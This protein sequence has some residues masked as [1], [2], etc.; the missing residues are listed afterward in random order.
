MKKVILPQAKIAYKRHGRKGKPKLLMLHGLFT[1]SCY[2]EET[3]EFLKDEFDILTPD[4]PG[5]GYSDKL[6]TLPHNLENFADIVRQL[7]E[8]VDFK[9]FSL[10]GASLGAITSIVFSSKYPDFVDNVVLQAPPWKDECVNMKFTNKAFGFASNYKGLVK[11]AGKLKNGVRK[12]MFRSAIK[13]FNK[14]YLRIE[15]RN[16]KVSFSFRTMNLEASSDVWHNIRDLD[17]TNY[18]KK[19]HKPT[20]IISG[21]HDEQVKPNNVKKLTEV[22]PDSEFKLL[23]GWDCTHALFFDY[24]EKMAR[25]IRSFLMG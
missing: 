15:E 8:H 17:L 10:V 5:F 2:F 22:I 7:C 20:L 18:A 3:I 4:L 24:P 11:I 14:H 9:P 16:E 21:D 6:K 1:N 19:I 13:I 12:E 23:K 25:L